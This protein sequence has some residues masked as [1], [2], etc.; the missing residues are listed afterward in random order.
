MS[1]DYEIRCACGSEYEHRFSLDN[2]RDPKQVQSLI[3]MRE[4]LAA[5]GKLAAER[6]MWMYGWDAYES[7]FP[8][9]FRFFAEHE[10]HELRVYD[11]YGERWPR[12]VKR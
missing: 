8:R 9:A 1:T 10:G 11:E 6:D 2:W 5:I 7:M 4:G 3:D 12:E